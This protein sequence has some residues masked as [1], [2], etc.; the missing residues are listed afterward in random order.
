MQIRVPDNW[1]VVYAK[2]EKEPKAIPGEDILELE[3]NDPNTHEIKGKF[4]CSVWGS[5]VSQQDIDTF[6]GGMEIEMIQTIWKGQLC[7]VGI[8]ESEIGPIAFDLH[9]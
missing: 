1:N 9:S 4:I 7:F 2:T 6:I 8:H 5:N 3:F